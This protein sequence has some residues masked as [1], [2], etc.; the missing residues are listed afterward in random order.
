MADARR[1]RAQPQRSHH[2]VF[3]T[4]CCLQALEAALWRGYLAASKSTVPVP[5]VPASRGALRVPCSAQAEML[6]FHN[7]L[8]DILPGFHGGASRT[9]GGIFASLRHA[10][11]SRVKRPAFAV[12]QPLTPH[13]SD[14]PLITNPS[15][16]GNTEREFQPRIGRLMRP[17]SSSTVG[18]STVGFFRAP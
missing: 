17:I 12:E 15:P 5:S 4:R 7:Q 16:H 3:T 9:T 14:L 2:R 11:L 8:R 13:R 1:Q 18:S 6:R 10:L